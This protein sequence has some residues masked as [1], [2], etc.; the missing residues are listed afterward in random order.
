MVDSD[1]AL[2]V[3]VNVLDELCWTNP[4]TIGV[5]VKPLSVSLADRPPTDEFLFVHPDTS[6]TSGFWFGL[7]GDAVLGHRLEVLEQEVALVL[8]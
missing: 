4:P 5:A 3:A 7:G 1:V 2:A 6:G 8:V